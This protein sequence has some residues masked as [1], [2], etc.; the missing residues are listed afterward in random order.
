MSSSK[1]NAQEPLF[2]IAVM[3]TQ[4]LM[5]FMDENVLSDFFVSK[6]LSNETDL[7]NTEVYLN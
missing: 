7:S 3:F 4:S 2:D 6:A 1:I 5:Q